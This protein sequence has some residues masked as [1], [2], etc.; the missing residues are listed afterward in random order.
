MF[1]RLSL[2]VNDREVAFIEVGSDEEV[3]ESHQR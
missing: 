1:I 3:I 2:Q